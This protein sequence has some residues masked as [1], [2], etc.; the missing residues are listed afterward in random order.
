MLLSLLFQRHIPS[1]AFL[2]HQPVKKHTFRHNSLNL[3]DTARGINEL[4][5]TGDR[6]AQRLSRISAAARNFHRN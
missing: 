1:T 3:H 6:Q 5:I 2:F 4:L